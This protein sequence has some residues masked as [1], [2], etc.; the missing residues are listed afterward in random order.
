MDKLPL[1]P[2]VEY[3]LIIGS[4][5][6]STLERPFPLSVVFQTKTTRYHTFGLSRAGK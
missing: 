6:V 1:N 5:H 4:A 2:D 3:I